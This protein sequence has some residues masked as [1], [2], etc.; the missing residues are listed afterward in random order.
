MSFQI[1]KARGSTAPTVDPNSQAAK[2]S[3]P[4]PNAGLLQPYPNLAELPPAQAK[5]W[6][7]KPSAKADAA[8]QVFLE[9]NGAI[10]DSEARHR[11]GEA[12]KEATAAVSASA[13]INTQQSPE[14]SDEDTSGPGATLKDAQK[15][16]DKAIATKAQDAERLADQQAENFKELHQHLQD[17]ETAQTV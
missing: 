12:I 2:P 15:S 3:Q 10:G 7:I 8:R 9:R 6:D 4:N 13:P 17:L 14:P 11:R 16:N 1:G 5:P